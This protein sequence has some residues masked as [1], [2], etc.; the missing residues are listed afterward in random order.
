MLP[1]LPCVPQ[2]PRVPGGIAESQCLEP[3]LSG[4][5]AEC[6]LSPPSPASAALPSLAY[7]SGLQDSGGIKW[8]YSGGSPLGGR[9]QVQD[10][11]WGAARSPLCR[12]LICGLQQLLPFCPSAAHPL[13]LGTPPSM[14]LSRR[15]LVWPGSAPALPSP[16][17]SWE[18]QPGL[19]IGARPQL[20][21]TP[22]HL[23]GDTGDQ[24]RDVCKPQSPK[25][26]HSRQ[27]R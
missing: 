11:P 6:P 16:T 21:A 13:P 20:L 1:P 23:A 12:G 27:S 3:C 14:G 15:I 8:A 5:R 26:S 2:R 18:S 25:Q 4:S 9:A 7:D 10:T 22:G 17:C 24:G 19:A